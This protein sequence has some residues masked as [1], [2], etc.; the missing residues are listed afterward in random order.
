MPKE[1]CMRFHGGVL[2]RLFILVSALFVP[3][4]IP[5]LAQVTTADITGR[6]VD[7]QGGAVPGAT[8]TATNTATSQSRSTT[9]NADGDFT[10]S[11]L[12]PGTYDITVEAQGFSRA[13]A[14]AVEANVGARRSLNVELKPGARSEEHTSELQSRL[15][16]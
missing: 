14:K 9:S 13:A 2:T 10:I 11:E 4:M 7:Q 3:L 5:A 8:I 12:A 16:L 15:H 6:V 1:V